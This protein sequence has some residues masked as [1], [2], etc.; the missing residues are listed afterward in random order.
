[1]GNKMDPRYFKELHSYSESYLK[2][3]IG[4]KNF[5][6]LVNK[7]FLVKSDEDSKKFKGDC[8]KFRYVGMIILGDMILKKLL[9]SLNIS[10]TDMIKK[11]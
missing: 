7:R 4:E 5:F 3:T 2:S 8:Y 10:M 1:M 6:E 11:R 9:K